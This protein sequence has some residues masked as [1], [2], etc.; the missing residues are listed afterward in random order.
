MTLFKTR[1]GAIKRVQKD[2]LLDLM[3]NKVSSLPI[4]AA[5]FLDCSSAIDS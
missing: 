4:S 2:I 5:M 3:G 1:E